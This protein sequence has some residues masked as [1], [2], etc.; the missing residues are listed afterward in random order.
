VYQTLGIRAVHL[1]DPQ[2]YAERRVAA[3]TTVR[4]SGDANPLLQFEAAASRY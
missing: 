2:E 1:S 3:G 4:D